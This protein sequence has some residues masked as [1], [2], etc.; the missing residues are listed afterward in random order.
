MKTI[1]YQ[2]NKETVLNRAKDYYPNNKKVSREEQ[3]IEN[4]LK[5]IEYNK[6]I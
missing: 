6:R 5:K 4:Y 1:Y 2:G 3:S